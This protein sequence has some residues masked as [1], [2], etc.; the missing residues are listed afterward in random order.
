MLRSEAIRITV[1]FFLGGLVLFG[2]PIISHA[3]SDP[4]IQD[5]MIVGNFDRTP[6]LAGLNMQLTVP[7]YLRTDDSVIF[8]HVPIATDNNFITT[9]SG[10]T[11]FPPLSLWDD[12]SFLTPDP[13]EPITG[14]TNQ[15]FLGFAYLVDP[16]DPQNFLYTNNHWIHIADI[17]MTTSSNIGIL[18]TTTTFVGGINPQNGDLVMGLQDGITEV[19]PAVVWGSIYFPPNNPPV[20]VSPDTGT[21]PVNEQF[22][23]T[24][25]VTATDPD[26][27][28]MVLT[29]DFGPTNYIFNQ[30][31]NIPG[32]ISFLFNWV[33]GPGS[34]GT[35]PLTFTVNDGNGGV[36][37]RNLTLIVSPA[38]LSIGSANTLPGSPISVPVSLNNPGSSSAVGGFE[39]LVS[40]NPEALS[41]NGVTRAGRLGSF[42]YF[43][44]TYS[45]AGQG[46][47]RIVG[48]ADIR[49]GVVSPPLH[50]GTGPIFFLE[51]SVAPDEALIGVDLQVNFLNLDPSDNT[52]SDSTGYLLVH[53]ELTNGLISVIGPG[54]VLTGD[55]NLDGIPY[56]VSDAVIFVN[57]LTS[58]LLFPFNAIQLEASDVNADGIP[59][60][61]ADLVYLLNIINGSIP[62]PK[63][64]PFGG[65]VTLLSSAENGNTIFSANSPIDLGGLLIKITHESGLSL[66]PISNGQ[67]TIAYND[68][69]TVLTV[70]A[71]LPNGGRVQAGNAPLFTLAQSKDKLTIS[72]LSA[73][74]AN[75]YLINAVYSLESP[76]P[77][78]YELAQ[79]YPN[80]FNGNTAISFGLP[81][82]SDV[83]LNIFNITGQ[84]VAT[85]AD[86]HFEA[87]RY[88]IIWNG[89]DNNGKVVSSGVYFYRLQAG[90][91]VKSNK[92]TM[93]K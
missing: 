66:R 5:S 87:G 24:F 53:P 74:D 25:I 35:Y 7:I 92:M 6:I 52:L 54:E 91:E 8:I 48:I 9:R 18:G 47:A 13:N 63:L 2:L 11:F 41:L 90:S 19:R 64:E 72:D 78:E 37:Q 46:T 44:I 45:D 22:G 33:P 31:Q 56:T 59:S 75:G 50:P 42:E 49:N 76:I 57:H 27:D 29:A 23:A 80:P 34:S 38:G 85:L 51:M 39:I 21:F 68:D 30:I 73:S 36:L 32:R 82:A 28:S 12:K 16:R 58:P 3:Q 84:K 10:G 69:G 55:I 40:Y 65:V 61:V 88:N 70:L 4:G 83:N 26:T 20:F 14:F 17:R 15:S 86:G 93:L 79:N 77:S 60:T 1:A 43:H 67:F 89:I 62:R 81:Q 71:Y